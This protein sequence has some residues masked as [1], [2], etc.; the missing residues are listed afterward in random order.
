MR[1][2]MPSPDLLR[3]I[4][5][6]HRAAP[7]RPSQDRHLIGEHFAAV[8]D[9]AGDPT[10]PV[11]RDGGWYA[12]EFAARLGSALER[13]ACIADAVREV[14]TDLTATYDLHP[15][16]SPSST[17]AIA[18]WN[19]DTVETYVLGDSTLVVFTTGGQAHVV[20][21][22]RLER[23]GVEIRQAMR[24]H[25]AS[26]HGYDQHHRELLADLIQTARAHRNTPDGYWIAEATPDA[27]DHALTNTWPRDQ[28]AA[29]ILATDGAAAAVNT[30]RLFPDWPS[31]R[32]GVAVRG[33]ATL[34]R[35]IEQAEHDDPDGQRWP[36]S[37]ASDD[38]VLLG[39][40]LPVTTSPCS[41]P[42]EPQQ[43]PVVAGG[44]E[45]MGGPPPGRHA[46]GPWPH[47]LPP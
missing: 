5:I 46:H 24:D 20:C 39:V 25:L 26:G 28:V 34:L 18:R 22:Q 17:V 36:R 8:L 42:S 9:G 41:V 14:I 27:A 23:V 38:K 11:G 21:D 12:E 37:K 3:H 43:P 31:L 32:H 1:E 13:H 30:Y 15:G 10:E 19:D 33:G 16:Q 40:H 47:L 45:R 44:T 4:Q 35:A 29:L 7:G 2:H 6:A